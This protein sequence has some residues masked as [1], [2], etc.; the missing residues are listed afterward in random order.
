MRWIVIFFSLGFWSAYAQEEPIKVDTAAALFNDY[1]YPV[2]LDS[3]IQVELVAPETDSIRVSPQHPDV[4]ISTDTLKNRLKLLN[5]KTPLNIV[6]NPNLEHLIRSF[7]KN[8]RSSLEILMSRSQ[9]YF[10]L[11]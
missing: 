4:Y 11:F 2:R 3:I 1:Q 7:L 8:R 6:Y 9:Y 5:A 10:P